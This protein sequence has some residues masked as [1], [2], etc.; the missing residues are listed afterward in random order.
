ML[1]VGA[2][3]IE[4]RDRPLGIDVRRPRFSWQLLS[5]RRGVTQ[6]QYRLQVATDE[7]F[8]RPFWDSGVVMSDENLQVEYAGPDLAPRTRYF[9]RV[10]VWDDAGQ[11]SG[12]SGP[13]YWETG[14]LDAAE[15][16]A[17]WITADTPSDEICPLLRRQFHLDGEPVQAR[18]YVTALG[19]YEARINGKRVGDAVLTPGWTSYHHRVQ[20]QTYDVRDLLT[21]G[22][23]VLGMTLGNGWFRGNLA[24]EGGRHLYGDRRAAI[25][26]LHVRYADGR[27]QVVRSDSRWKAHPGPIVFAEIYHGETYDARCEI[28]GWDRPGFDDSDW[29]PVEILPY[30]KRGLVGQIGEPVKVIESR[31]PQ[32]LLRTPAGETVIDMGQNLVGWVRFRVRGA[33]GA[34]VTLQ[35]VE[36]L[37]KDGN[38]YT[39]NLRRARQTVTYIC[40]GDGT[41]EEFVPHFTFQGFRYVKVVEYP[42]VLSLDNFTAEVVHSHLAMTG[43]FQCSD[44]LVN[45]LQENIIWSQ[46]GNF[47][48]VPTD[49]PQRDER[50]GWT[51]DAAAFIS[52]ALFNMAAGGFFTKWL[53]DLRFDQ[54]PDGGVPFVIPHVLP[55]REEHSSAAWGDAATICPWAVYLAYRDRRLLAEQYPSMKAWVEY[56]RRQGDDEALWNTGFHFG[57]WL[58]LDAEEGSYV[59]ATPKDLIA[60]AYYAHSCDLT[61]RAARVLGLEED[62]AAY[63]ALHQRIVTRFQ[64]TF[65]QESGAPKAATQ[66]AYV[67]AL[68][69]GLVPEDR[70]AQVA[71]E[72]ADMIRETG[73]LTTGFVG[74]PFVLHVL[75]AF[76]HHDLACELVRRRDYPSWLYAV[77]RGAT[78]IWE[79]WDGLKPDGSF[80]SPQMNSFNHYAYGSV[81]DFLYRVL[82]GL[83]GDEAEPGYRRI[84]ITP[85]PDPAFSYALAGYAAMVGPIRAGWRREG[86]DLL[87]IAEIPPNATASVW[88]P[89]AQP[90]SVRENDTPL[91]KTAGVLAVEEEPD[92]TRVEVGSGAY[93]FRYPARR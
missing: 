67:L 51:G 90:A 49:C 7:R 86:D 76:G 15:W 40:R 53:Q 34:R 46:R 91:E 26:E 43:S 56:I 45:R 93:A 9:V 81:G 18:L 20:Y 75:S 19:L 11:W 66:T 37:D 92:G 74:T 6:R 72:L 42:G 73:Y 44:P 65:L 88:L 36:V 50:L 58:G 64:E 2:I 12:W 79:H 61:A 70:R 8:E 24:W 29:R 78:T 16:Q 38:V 83:N 39:E 10:S 27:T 33:P 71:Q 87:V 25:A 5:D 77:E 52:T 48:D 35:H 80:W 84:H 14:F 57:D 22:E 41:E 47:V 28:P 60:T 69:F 31:P 1:L 62:A 63:S 55:K 32:A 13:T 54:R 59:G 85:H 23:N 89:G 30:D 4:Y 3:H 21:A 68:H 82:A 17:D